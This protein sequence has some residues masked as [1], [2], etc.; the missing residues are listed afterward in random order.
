[1]GRGDV[2]QVGRHRIMCGDATCAEDVELLMDGVKADAVVTDPPYG[3]NLQIDRGH[4]SRDGDYTRQYHSYSDVIND[5]SPFDRKKFIIDCVEEFWFGADYYVDTLDNFGKDGSWLVWNKRAE[6]GNEKMQ[7]SMFE[8]IWSKQKHRREV[9]HFVWNGVLGHVKQIDGNQ[10]YHPTQKSAKMIMYIL[11][12]W[13]GDVI[14]DPFVGS[15]TTI[16]ACEQTGRVGYGMEIAPE[17]VAVCL[18]RLSAMGLEAV[19]VE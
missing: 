4:Y 15:G 14:V 3:M 5:E 8:L 10:K 13:C 2:W 1:M 16:V 12:K 6:G 18:E 9:L 7:G 11:D 17:Y 19:R